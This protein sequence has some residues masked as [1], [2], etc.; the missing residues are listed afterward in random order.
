M[1]STDVSSP[2]FSAVPCS[3][4]THTMGFETYLYAAFSR[5]VTG[6]HSWHRSVIW[7]LGKHCP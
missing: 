3:L 5:H 7:S 6:R 1:R 2:H 4:K